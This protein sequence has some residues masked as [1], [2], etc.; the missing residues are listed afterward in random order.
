MKSPHFKKETTK[1]ILIN[2]IQIIRSHKADLSGILYTSM[3]DLNVNYIHT[4]QVK[5]LPDTYI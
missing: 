2:Q 1:K 4:I 5:H 3:I